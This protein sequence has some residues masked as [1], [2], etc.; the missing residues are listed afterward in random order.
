MKSQGFDVVWD[1]E[2]NCF[3]L[4][5]PPLCMADVVHLLTELKLGFLFQFRSEHD[6]K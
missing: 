5:H 2:R 6:K 4:V 3:I 1:E